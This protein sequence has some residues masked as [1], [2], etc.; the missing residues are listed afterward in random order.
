MLFFPHSVLSP[1][2]VSFPPY[3]SL[4]ATTY[5]QR[6]PKFTS[7][8]QISTRSSRLIHPTAFSIPFWG[9]LKGIPKFKMSKTEL[10]PPLYPTFSFSVYFSEG[11]HHLIC[12]ESLRSNSVTSFS[13]SRPGTSFSPLPLLL[14]LLPLLYQPFSIIPSCNNLSRLPSSLF[15]KTN[16]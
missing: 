11:Y 1:Q 13:I 14:I 10:N 6:T 12:N 9:C 4:S 15:L 8:A 7:L 5:V 2:A 3:A 16:F